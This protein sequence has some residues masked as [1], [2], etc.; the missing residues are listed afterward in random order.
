TDNASLLLAH[1]P[2]LYSLLSQ[3]HALFHQGFE[4]LVKILQNRNFFLL[5]LRLCQ[6]SY[7]IVENYLP[8]F[9]LLNNHFL[10][11][12]LI[13]YKITLPELIDNRDL[14]A[15]LAMHAEEMSHIYLLRL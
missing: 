6:G 13:E 12:Y 4:T 9:A 3:E 14:F 10:C 1:F 5:A 2:M 15:L 7:A 11:Q 8:L